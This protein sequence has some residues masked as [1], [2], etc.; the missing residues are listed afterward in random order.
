MDDPLQR[1]TSEWDL[2]EPDP[3]L[4]YFEDDPDLVRVELTKIRDEIRAE[5]ARRAAR[6]ERPA[7]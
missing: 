5:K 2:I 4:Y 6:G 3:Y 1:F 7:S